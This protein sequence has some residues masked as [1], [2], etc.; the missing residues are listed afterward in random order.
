M[1]SA[2]DGNTDKI[3]VTRTQS[4]LSQ[5]SSNYN[6]TETEVGDKMVVLCHNILRDK[7]GI[8]QK[9]Q[10]TMEAINKVRMT[11]PNKSDF[12]KL[13]VVYGVM[14][15]AGQSSNEAVIRLNAALDMDRSA[16]DIFLNQK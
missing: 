15:N 6:I 1:L 16:L 4:L 2:I 9:I 12:E 5:L 13:L 7:Y 10:T 8:N 3:Y 14:R 11:S